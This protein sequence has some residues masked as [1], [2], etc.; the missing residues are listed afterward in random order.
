MP[1]RSN[2][3]LEKKLKEKSVFRKIANVI[4]IDRDDLYKFINITDDKVVWTDNGGYDLYETVIDETITHK[5]GTHGLS[6]LIRVSKDAILDKSFNLEE[7]LI[8]IL[9]RRFAEIE[10]NAFIHGDGKDKP[11]GI[12]SSKKGAKVGHE[13]NSL[14]FDDLKKL[15][16]S[17]DPEFRDNACWIMNDETAFYLHELKDNNGN[18][19]WNSEANTLFGKQVYFVKDMPSIKT[20]NTP[21]LFGDFSYYWIIQ[22]HVPTIKVLKELD[23]EIIR[24]FVEKI[25]VEQSQK[26]EGTRTKKQTIWIVWNYIG[27][28]DIPDIK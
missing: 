14:N 3:K 1:A 26:I 19:L 25:Y 24:V 28:V 16:F 17:L 13:T 5:I 18:Y 12:L 10:T 11:Y 21:I 8:N 15:Y 6:T 22:R 7:Q 4:T 20:G 23:A 27:Q 9:S 2:D